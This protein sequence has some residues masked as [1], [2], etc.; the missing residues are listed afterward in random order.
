S[1]CMSYFRRIWA[2]VL[3]Y[4]WYVL[5][6]L[7]VAG[8]VAFSLFRGGGEVSRTTGPRQVE[9]A[10]V[11]DLVNGGG[12]L[13]VIAEIESTSEAKISPETGGKV[14]R[15]RTSLGSFVGAGQ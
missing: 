3:A 6:G 9:V 14:T 8:A 10:R 15:V 7:V 5:A 13:S 11:S 12:S 1:S 4:K 2:F